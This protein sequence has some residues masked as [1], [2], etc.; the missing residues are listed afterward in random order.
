MKNE[1]DAKKPEHEAPELRI[2]DLDQDKVT[3]EQADALRG[4]AATR[5]FTDVV[6]DPPA[7]E[8]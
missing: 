6:L 8:V 1:R 3:D 7:R 2:E 4:G 5:G